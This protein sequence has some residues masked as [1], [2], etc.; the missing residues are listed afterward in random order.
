MPL[1]RSRRRCSNG[2]STIIVRSFREHFSPIFIH[3]AELVRHHLSIV[4]ERTKWHPQTFLDIQDLLLRSTMQSFI[5]LSMG[6]K[7]DNLDNDGKFDAEGGYRFPIMPFA[8]A[9]DGMNVISNK[10][11]INPLHKITERLDGTHKTNMEYR[12]TLH[13]FAQNIIDQKRAARV[14]AG[15]SG[16]GGSG[17]SDMLDHFLDVKME[18]GSEPSDEQLCDMVLNMIIAGRDTTAQTMS[19]EFTRLAVELSLTI[20]PRPGVA[21]QISSHPE[22]GSKIRAEMD[23]VLGPDKDKLPSYADVVNLKYCMATFLE[24]LRVNSNVPLNLKTPVTEAV[25]PGTGT[26]VYPGQRLSYSTFAM[27]RSK[28]IWGEDADEFRPERWIDEK[29]SVKTESAFKYRELFART[30]FV[31]M[32]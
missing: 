17:R 25:L 5:A 28:R 24:T 30:I 3:D 14:K 29:G 21:Y 1:S 23:S 6:A 2:S 22:V 13:D 15:G 32:P 18:D 10:R 20:A 4:A 7:M 8:V 26:R 19:C 31:G 16:D 11:T 12:K 9:F 27:G